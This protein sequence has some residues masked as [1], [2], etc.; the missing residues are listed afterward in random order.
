LQAQ[1]LE[2]HAT[3]SPAFRKA[4]GTPRPD[5]KEAVDE[6]MKAIRKHRSR[7]EAPEL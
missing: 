5:L 7:S 3:W 4:I 1:A 2:D 6:M